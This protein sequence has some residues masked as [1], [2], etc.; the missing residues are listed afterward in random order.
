MET[1]KKRSGKAEARHVGPGLP[2]LVTPGIWR[3]KVCLTVS[4]HNPEKE[5][6]S[7]VP[8][9]KEMAFSFSLEYRPK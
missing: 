9:S 1:V 7:H 8:R 2:A 4:K 5:N 3:V 6:T